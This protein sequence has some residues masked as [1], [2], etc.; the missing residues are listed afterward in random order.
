[1]YRRT[2]FCLLLIFAVA[3]WVLADQPTLSRETAELPSE[4][5]GTIQSAL[6]K[7]ALAVKLGGETAAR[8]WLVPTA[9]SAPSPSTQLGVS[10]GAVEPGSLVGVVQITGTWTDYKKNPIQ[11]GVY[12]LRY[13]VMP[14]DGNHMGVAIYRDFLLLL[15][16]AHDPGP[17]QT[18]S[19]DDMVSASVMAAGVPHPAV[20]SL[21][22]VWDEI[23]EPKLLKNDVDQWML[24]VKLG[25]LTFGLVVEGHGEI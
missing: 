8:F 23:S 11:A 13:C 24:G 12:T 16:P 14:A 22:P 7:E 10:L 2:F 21:F 9:K 4:L 1:M 25:D 5:P 19:Y 15:P 17:E 6:G 20:L 18:I 3:G